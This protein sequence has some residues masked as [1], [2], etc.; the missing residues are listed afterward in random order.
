MTETYLHFRPGQLEEWSQGQELTFGRE[1]NR[2]T[3]GFL[4][5]QAFSVSVTQPV[6]LEG[7]KIAAGIA[8]VHEMARSVVL[9]HRGKELSQDGYV[10]FNNDLVDALK[11]TRDALN[12]SLL[13]VRE[14]IFEQ[15]RLAEFADKPSRRCCVFLAPDT[16]DAFDYWRPLNGG[17][18]VAYRVLVEGNVHTAAEIW[19]GLD[20]ASLGEFQQRARNYWSGANAETLPAEIIAEGKVTVL[21]AVTPP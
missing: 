13:F 1:L 17:N 21:D 7:G 16:Q 6:R 12:E 20:V 19:T 14:L 10:R 2:W 15:V 5:L 4:D 18:S 3:T 9:A 8:P 11:V